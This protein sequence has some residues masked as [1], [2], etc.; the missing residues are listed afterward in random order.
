MGGVI[1]GYG[2]RRD[3]TTGFTDAGDIQA[4]QDG[5]VH[6]QALKD[7]EAQ[8]APAPAAAPDATDELV[9]GAAKSAALRL[10]SASGRKNSFLTGPLDIGTGMGAKPPPG[11][12]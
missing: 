6:A 8:T 1:G 2:K 10:M 7:T 5:V 3:G 12:Y 11:G 4:Q 9:R